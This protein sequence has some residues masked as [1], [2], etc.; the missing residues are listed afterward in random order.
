VPE[1]AT[2][3]PEEAPRQP[4]QPETPR[5]DSAD[6]SQVR[7]GRP[8]LGPGLTGEEPIRARA[9][10]PDGLH[11]IVVLADGR[12]IRCS[13]PACAVIR[14]HYTDFLT[15]QKDPA[16]QPDEAMRTLAADF[17]TRMAALDARA[18]GT[19]DPAE[20]QR[21]AEEV[22]RLDQELR[23]F[24]ARTLAPELG[25]RADRLVTIL[26]VWTAEQARAMR[27]WLGPD[28]F[29]HL[30]GRRDPNVIRSF[31][32]A[33]ELAGADDVAR[34][35]LR[36]TLDLSR[37][38]ISEVNFGQALAQLVDFM[39][40]YGSRVSGDFIS[41]YRRAVQQRGDPDQARA[42]LRLAEDI[43]EGRT[44]LGPGTRVAGL[45]AGEAE[46]VR[47]PEYRVTGPPG[48]APRLVEVKR[49]GAPL[50]EEGLDR[51]L[52][53]AL[54]QIIP[55]SEATG[56]RGG[57]VRIDATEGGRSA[58]T[59]EQ[60]RQTVNRRLLSARPDPADPTRSTRGIDFVRWVE[61]LYQDSAGNPQ[62][63]LCEV[64]SGAVVIVP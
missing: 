3:R 46:G 43:L 29:A 53:S 57:F 6:P 9:T 32:R 36:H 44:P 12:I 40:R 55:T 39:D 10:T 21:V 35:E 63:V 48:T 59:P 27:T 62:R 60:V 19:A 51:N 4:A 50:A 25:V 33:L 34:N 15:E 28:L 31:A 2:P 38:G 24:A 20:A 52:R 30:A 49:I 23:Q 42:E 5:G 8:Q 37:G 7:P 56:E 11:Q 64:Q 14:V 22:A 1:P 61:V 41:R 13:S 16:R 58:M 47:A 17:E 26:E 54:G 18:A 45:P